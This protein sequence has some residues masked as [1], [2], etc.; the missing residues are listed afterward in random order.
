MTPKLHPQ[1]DEAARYVLDQLPPPARHEFE[2]QLT[3]SPELRALVQELE[4]GVEAMARAV[5]QR[6]P[7]PQTWNPIEQAIAREVERKI[8]RPSFG[9]TWWRSGWAAAA[10]CLVALF[11]YA[12]W[13]KSKMILAVNSSPAESALGTPA[14]ES[15]VSRPSLVP[16]ERV[17]PTNVMTVAEWK[18]VAN[19]TSPELASLR[20]QIAS[21]QAQ[22][23]Q[24]SDVVAQQRAI[25]AE[26]GRFK[27]FPLS[28]RYWRVWRC[29]LCAAFAGVATR[30][31]LRH[32]A[33]HG[34]AARPCY[35]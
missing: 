6:P 10:A 17:F 31:V 12:W 24:L 9:G 34:L 15:V 22:L 32:G 35:A 3:Q 19:L 27:F 13:P 11:T 21:M 20:W 14:V 28:S 5:P 30:H 26:P 23:E 29:E 7:P 8:V 25:L 18:P 16:P 2:L 1:A 4:E 33:G